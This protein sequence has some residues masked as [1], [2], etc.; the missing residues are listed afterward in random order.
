MEDDLR[1]SVITVRL[2]KTTHKQLMD[3]AHTNKTTLNRLCRS[4]LLG[5]LMD[6]THT[7][8]LVNKYRLHFDEESGRKSAPYTKPK[9]SDEE[10]AAR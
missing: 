2:P 10:V 1:T 6:G 9:V 4:V 5:A 7:T 3:L 8:K